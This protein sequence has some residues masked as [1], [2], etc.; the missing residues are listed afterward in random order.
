MKQLLRIKICGLK[1][2]QTIEAMNGLPIHEI[3]FVFAPSK[4][5]VDKTTA[6][7]LIKAVAHL[8]TAGEIRP[9][10]VG[11]FVNETF[12]NLQAILA[13]A[14]LDVVQLHGNETAG[15]CLEVRVKLNVQVW[16]VFSVKRDAGK[17]YSSSALELLS[18][19]QSAV[20]AVLIDAPGGGTGQTFDWQVIEDYKKA[21]EELGITLYVAGG[22]HAG[23][24]QEL[25][26]TYAPG[27]I[28]VSSGVETDG[29]KDIDKIRLFV[30]RV[31]EA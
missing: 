25:L 13:E 17:T 3:G 24:V 27:G 29:R 19:Y 2:V 20:D 11:V 18:P 15:F 31:M 28:D 4:R 5:Q 7:H 21:A 26:R 10:T 14:P 1:D 9:K 23:N 6:A 8:K 30:R 12:A 16:K 22:L